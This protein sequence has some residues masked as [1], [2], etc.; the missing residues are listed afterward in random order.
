MNREKKKKKTSPSPRVISLEQEF[1]A[2]PSSLVQNIDLVVTKLKSF[3]PQEQED[4][5]LELIAKELPELPQLFKS[6]WGKDANIDLAVT[7]SLGSWSSPQAVELLQDFAPKV[8]DKKLIKAMRRSL[9]RLKS[10]GWQ[11]AEI[12][13]QEPAIFSPPKLEPAQGYVSA[14]DSEGARLVLIAQPQIPKG[15]LIFQIF[16]RD[17]EGI[18][19]FFVQD[20]TKKSSAEYLAAFKENITSLVEV[21][22]N[23]A[24]GLIMESV[25]AGQKKGK[26]PPADFNQWL[27]YLGSPPAL[28][29]KPIVY[30]FLSIEEVTNRSDLLDRSPLLFEMPL[31]DG[32]F[33]KKEEL[34]KYYDL[35]K[36]ASTSRL[37]LSQQQKES[38]LQDIYALAAQELFSPDRRFLYRRRLEEMAYILFKQGKEYEARICLASALFL[39]KESGLLSPH[40]F[41]CALVQRSLERQLALEKEEREKKTESNLII[42]LPRE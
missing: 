22:P 2:A 41:L 23:Y 28:P 13:D 35:Y 1:T 25:E 40:T 24:L 11:V 20:F 15:T 12:T 5:F 6:I 18:L 33:L 34:Q 29:L 36:E 8:Q 39:E 14:Y 38:R 16:M 10:K 21:D 3:S 42:D 17:E 26:N 27:P 7:N 30:Q 31:F 9:F 37:V 32:W 19:N 4:F